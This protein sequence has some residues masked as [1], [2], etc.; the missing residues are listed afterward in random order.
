MITYIVRRLLAMIPTLILVSLCSF[1]I[2]RLPPGDFFDRFAAT[3]GT[4]GSSLDQATINNL[5]HQYSLDEPAYVQYLTW[6]AGFLH[7]DLGYSLQYKRPVNELIWDYLGWTL[8]ITSIGLVFTWIIAIPIGIYSATHQYSAGDIFFSFLGFLG[9]SVPDFALAL[10]YLAIGIFAFNASVTGLFSSGMERAP[11]SIAKVLDLANH[12]LWPSL[13]LGAA[14]MAQL[15]RIMRGSL[16]DVL[17]QQYVTT[18]RAKGLKES[19]VI[20]KYAVRVAINPL[21]SVMGMQLPELFSSATTLGIVLTLPT[22]GRILLD[23]LLSMDMY[24]AGSILLF[25]ALMLML[26]NLL[27]DIALAWVDPRIRLE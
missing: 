14:G 11:W 15:I 21:I 25:L 3:V 12:L 23:S 24:L 9:L 6:I 17:G 5:R 7:G 4:S 2:I 22:I 8:L 19:V 13:I 26:G 16:L 20:N 18:A 10:L 27:A 1:I